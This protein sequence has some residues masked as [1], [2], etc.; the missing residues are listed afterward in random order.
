MVGLPMGGS[1][2]LAGLSILPKKRSHIKRFQPIFGER[3]TSPLTHPN[4]VCEHNH[5]RIPGDGPLLET[6]NRFYSII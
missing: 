3:L 1:S 4:N 2:G 6:I 5:Q